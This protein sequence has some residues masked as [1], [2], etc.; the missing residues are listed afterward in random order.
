MAPALVIHLFPR[1]GEALVYDRGAILAGE[2]W[3]LLTGHWVHFSASHLIWDTA[4]LGAAFWIAGRRG[5]RL[6]PLLLVAATL[7]VGLGLLAL[8]PG[9]ERYGGLSGIAMAAVVF[10]AVRGLREPR[11]W[12]DACAWVLSVTAVKLGADACTASSFLVRFDDG[13]VT[14]VPLSHAL[15]AAAGALVALASGMRA[16]GSRNV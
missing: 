14:L 10:V 3:R 11:P 1:A 7:T 12:R 13:T 2:H 4:I 9:L 8:L 5:Y 16:G 15:G 6:L